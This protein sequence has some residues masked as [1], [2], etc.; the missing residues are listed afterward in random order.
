MK[1]TQGYVTDDGT[2]FESKLEAEQHEAEMALRSMLGVEY[3][4]VSADKFIEMVQNLMPSV[5]GYAD[6]YQAL[7]VTKRDQSTEDEDRTAVD[8]GLTTTPDTSTGHI[9]SAEK[10]LEA[11]LQL[12]ARGHGNVPD[13]GSRP[14]AKKIPDRRKVDGA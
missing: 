11:L 4:Q 5:R 1:M 3:P 7:Q 8:D 12:P 6:A 13:V 2:F 14:R 9:S 10:D